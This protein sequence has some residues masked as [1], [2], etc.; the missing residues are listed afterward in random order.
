MPAWRL[1]AS[2]A[3]TRAPLPTSLAAAATPAAA[4]VQ[5][6]AEIA[7]AA[8]APGAVASPAAAAASLT[9]ALT[10]RRAA[11]AAPTPLGPTTRATRARTA[12]AVTLAALAKTI[13]AKSAPLALTWLLAG[14]PRLAGG[15]ATGT[16]TSLSPLGP[17]G[18]ERRLTA[19]AL[20]PAVLLHGPGNA[21]EMGGVRAWL[22]L[23]VLDIDATGHRSRVGIEIGAALAK[24]LDHH[25]LAVVFVVMLAV[26]LLLATVMARVRSAGNPGSASIARQTAAT[27]RNNRLA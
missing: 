19:K 2:A 14:S 23:V 11:L 12:A 24:I 10:R 20:L 16:L 18:A 26:V 8:A 7:A 17:L 13:G 15:P 27:F 6:P 25:K 3:P 21:L 4:G 9:A 1:T 5:T 22:P